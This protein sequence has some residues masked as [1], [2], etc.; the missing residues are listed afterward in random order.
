MGSM[1]NVITWFTRG[2]TEVP[3]SKVFAADLAKGT[4]TYNYQELCHRCG[5]AGGF[6]HWPGFTC[7]DC[8]GL[9]YEPT[10]EAPVYTAERL[11]TLNAAQA[12]RDAAKQAKADAARTAERARVDALRTESVQAYGDVI[13]GLQA[14]AGADTFLE[15]LLSKFDTYGSLTEPQLDA[16]RTAIARLA[17]RAAAKAGSQHVGTVGARLDL[18]LTVE[19]T[20]HFEP[21]GYG[22]AASTMYLCRDTEGNRVVYTG[23]GD[24]LAKGETGTVKATVKEHGDY[25][26][27][28]QT[29]LARPKVTARPA[30]PEVAA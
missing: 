20:I 5:G 30:A 27:E 13:E 25:K 12:K 16:A 21:R 19:H 29:I 9:R 2:G 11:A 10:R 7:F 26:G 1:E 6:R 15:S 24:F 17:S 18:T 4:A 14:F 8:G 22:W 3:A 23:S 28:L